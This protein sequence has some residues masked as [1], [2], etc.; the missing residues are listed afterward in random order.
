M[1]ILQYHSR[2]P[3][4][5]FWAICAMTF[6]MFTGCTEQ[7]KQIEDNINKMLN[8][9]VI[10]PY[11]K[12]LMYKGPHTL[13]DYSMAE[14]L[15]LVVYVD[16]TECSS[17]YLGNILKWES[18]LDTLRINY[19]FVRTTILFAPSKIKKDSFFEK[20]KNTK[21]KYPLYIDT[22]NIFSKT[23]EDIPMDK[24]YHTFLMDEDNNVILV[25]DPLKNKKIKRMFFDNIREIKNTDNNQ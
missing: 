1:R 19:D 22:C 7:K 14:P 13:Y 12:I 18:M 23:N 21:F 15:N 3:D 11:Y 16:S 20:L 2:I 24:M 17:C 9:K 25:G 4:R 5:V 6:L 10:V 8:H